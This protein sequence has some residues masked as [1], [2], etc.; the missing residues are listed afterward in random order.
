MTWN[1]FERMPEL[2]KI[3]EYIGSELQGERDDSKIN[4]VTQ[5]LMSIIF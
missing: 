1:L 5:K 4:A 2:P 3:K